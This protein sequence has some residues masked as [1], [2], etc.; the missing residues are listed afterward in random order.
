MFDGKI[1]KFLFLILGLAVFAPVHSQIRSGSAFLKMLPG[2]RIQSMAA[3]GTAVLDDPHAIFAN[4]ANTSF[5]REWQWSASYTKWIADISNASFVYGHALP[6][7][8]SRHTRVALG[9]LYQGVPEFNNDATQYAPASANDFVASF[10]IGQPLGFISQNLS[11]GGNIKYF[12]STL[13]QYSASSMVCDFGITARTAPFRLTK[14]FKSVLSLGA[15][16]TQNGSDVTFIQAGTP[17]PKTFRTGLSVYLGAHKGL[18]MLVSADYVSAQDEQAYMALGGELMINRFLGINAGYNFGS[19]LMKNLTLGASIRLDHVG[20]SVGSAFPGKDNA[21]RLDV[22]TLDESEFFSRTYRGSATHFPTKPEAFVLRSPAHGDSVF[23]TQVVLR[24][25]QARDLDVYDHVTYRVLADQDSA[26]IA[27]ILSAHSENPELF[28]SL[29]QNPLDFNRET[30]HTSI[31]MDH[32][33]GGD[34]YWAV[35]A[36]DADQQI[37]I[38]QTQNGAIARFTV[39][40]PD[41]EMRDIVFEPNPEITTDEFQGL[42]RVTLDRKSTRLNSSHYS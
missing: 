1:K 26:N 35:V 5:L 6:L 18:Q 13:A 19:D 4:P 8:W 23:T 42:V 17:L 38:G 7:P 10:S 16:M 9:L 24:W 2:A 14:S 33:Q 39:P 21:F 36:M 22:A 30:I 12:K 37:Q 20:R 32:V 11:V 34:Y 25:H 29:L 41:I 27:N 31:P 40:L 3:V 15:A 28:M